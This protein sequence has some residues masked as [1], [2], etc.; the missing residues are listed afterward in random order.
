MRIYNLHRLYKVVTE[1]WFL[2]SGIRDKN[3]TVQRKKK[4]NYSVPS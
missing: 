3:N 1:P 4:R 2:V